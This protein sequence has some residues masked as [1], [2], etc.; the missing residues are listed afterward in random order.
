MRGDGYA[1]EERLARPAVFI[2]RKVEIEIALAEGHAGRA[3][4]ILESNRRDGLGLRGF[5]LVEALEA[6][7]RA[8]RSAGRLE[9]AA[10]VLAQLLQ[11]HGYHALAHYE[12]GT[13]YEELGRPG[14][15]RL[16]YERFLEMWSGADAGV[17]Q[18]VE[19]RR[20]LAALKQDS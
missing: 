12:L 9:D 3:L 5:Y 6:G 8:H 20:R 19:A 13:I 14:D 4:E 7:A 16:E 11:V 15:A 10:D 17:T 18:L 2:A 1:S